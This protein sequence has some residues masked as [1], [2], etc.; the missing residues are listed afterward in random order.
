M[1]AFSYY[2][3]KFGGLLILFYGCYQLFLRKETL[4]HF[5]RWLLLSGLVL[6]VI[7][8]ILSITKIVK[9]PMVAMP[10][11]TQ[12]ISPIL[13]AASSS[14]TVLLYSFI[15]LYLIG[16]C[17]LFIRLSR[18][19]IFVKR[20]IKNGQ[21]LKCSKFIYIQCEGK[22]QPFSFF[23]YIVYNPNNHS[24]SEL[25]IIMAHEE[26]H[27]VQYHSLDVIL[28]ELVCILQW[29]NPVIWLY[30]VAIKQNLEFLADMD[31]Q[32]I[33]ID[34]KQYQYT[35]LQQA[36]G[37]HQ[38]SIVNPFFNSL[39]KKRIVMINQN[40]SHKSKSLK[41]LILLPLLIFFM[42]SFNV[43]TNYTFSNNE[44]L[45]N[46]ANTIELVIDKNTTD[47][48][49]LKIKADLAKEKFDFSYIVVRNDEREIKTI[50]LEISG[51][52]KTSGEV[53][54]RYN[55]AS[56]NDTIDP[57][58]IF[59]DTENNSISMG[60][61]QVIKTPA[62]DQST[63]WIHKEEGESS[64]KVI[65]ENSNG[66]KEIIING[67]KLTEEELEEMDIETEDGTYILIE[68]ED[69][70]SDKQV[71]IRKMKSG[72]KKQ[73]F[74]S[75]APSKEHD[76]QIIEEE[77]N[78]YFFMYTDGDKEPL[79]YIDGKKSDAKSL[80]ELNPSEIKSVNVLKGDAA[81]N[82]YG[83]KA[84]HGAVEITTKN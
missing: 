51:G 19:G 29:F 74:I 70:N 45:A 49:L 18:Q 77:G 2:L 76:I 82:K 23:N 36:V 46:A 80:K 8:P 48:Q 75:T 3:F 17:F 12:S 73:V 84:K 55:S 83:K 62:M 37:N 67:K 25:K 28:I 78:G 64:E 79:Y 66:H 63:V 26:V 4:F 53:S 81:A 27:A 34:K 59:I 31:N 41:S 15:G 72:A 22:I 5:N 16:V 60:N 61:G 42:V 7:L 21:R 52:S 11:G 14:S 38:L 56:D 50:S 44:L 39:I 57:T 40:Q 1:E 13:V 58:Y 43:K 6:S 24:E 54:S 65:I 71:N 35:L 47:E 69:N 33:K 32:E 10:S 20:I 30:K 9:V 68:K